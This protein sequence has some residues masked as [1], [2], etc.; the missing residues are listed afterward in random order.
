MTEKKPVGRPKEIQDAVHVHTKVERT[1]AE[2]AKKNHG[3]IA[4]AIRFAAANHKKD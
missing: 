3:S 4:N 1:D 2:K